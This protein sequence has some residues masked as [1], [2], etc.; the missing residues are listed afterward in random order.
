[1]QSRLRLA[2]VIL[3]LF[4]VVNSRTTTEIEG[5]YKKECIVGTKDP[6]FI[7]SPPHLT[8]E[9]SEEEGFICTR[10]GFLPIEGI[11]L[12]ILHNS[13]SQNFVHYYD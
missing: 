6:D 9:E 3:L 11:L 2:I 7:C 12:N 13:Q 5:I 4:T 10:K 8:C 1:M